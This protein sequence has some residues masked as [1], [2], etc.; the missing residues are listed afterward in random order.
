[1]SV[2]P[3]SRTI[4]GFALALISAGLATMT[5]MVAAATS[6]QAQTTTTS[7]IVATT[8]PEVT[9]ISI[10]GTATANGEKIPPGASITVFRIDNEGHEIDCGRFTTE[11]GGRFTLSLNVDCRDAPELGYRI[12][13]MSAEAKTAEEIKEGLANLN[14]GFTGLS[15]EEL[16]RLGISL[17]ASDIQQVPLIDQDSLQLILMTVIIVSALVLA[18][19]LLASSLNSGNSFQKPTEALVLIAVITA[20][21]ILGVTGKIGSDGLISV[22]AAIVGWTAARASGNGSTSAVPTVITVGPNAPEARTSSADPPVDD[23]ESGTAPATVAAAEPE[24]PEAPK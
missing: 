4:P 7:T 23:E 14:I 2:S 12:E 17:G 16:V 5:V 18:G 1:M 3:G 11:S 21:I 10:S 19:L 20:V 9:T 24:P 15:D 13:G 22:L 8:S 6:A